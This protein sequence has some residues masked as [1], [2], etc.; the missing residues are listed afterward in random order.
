LTALRIHSLIAAGLALL[1]AAGCDLNLIRHGD[2]RA[3]DS[4]PS[5]KVLVFGRINYVVD[6]KPKTPYGS[7]RPAWPAPRLSALQLESGDPFATPAVADADGSFQWELAPGHY[8]VSRIGVG[9]IWDDTFIAWPRVAFRVPPGARLAY[10]GHLVLDGT[11]YTEEFTYS[12]GR[13]STTSG[14]RYRFEV[15]DEME[16][17]FAG[18]GPAGSG[19]GRL[20]VRSLMFHDPGMLIGEPLL[21]AWRASR[22]G[23][24]ARIFHR[25][26]T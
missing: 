4:L 12:T 22:D 13:R 16:V 26:G 11:S 21:D 5:D 2:V 19:A 14:I 24:I 7:F 23:V 1:V 10:L 18:F 8:V 9:Q 17:Q 25:P 20:V 15:R 3:L 6:G